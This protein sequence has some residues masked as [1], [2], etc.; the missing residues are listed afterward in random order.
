MGS[1]S[2]LGNGIDINI[3]DTPLPEGSRERKKKITDA[4]ECMSNLHDK[5]SPH[6]DELG[7]AIDISGN[8]PK[9]G[10]RVDLP[11]ARERMARFHDLPNDTQQLRDEKFAHI[12]EDGEKP[13]A[14]YSSDVKEKN[15]DTPNQQGDVPNKEV[16]TNEK[17]SELTSEEKKK[18]KEE[19][20]W[21]DE[22]IDAIGSMEEYEIYKKAGLVEQEIN[23]KKCLVR[24]DIDWEQKDSMG[25]TNKERV[26]QGLSPINKKGEVIELH[27]IGQHADS[28]LAE[29]TQEEH[30]GKG[31]DTIL[32]DKTKES[33]IDRQE[34][35]EERSKHWEERAK[36]ENNQDK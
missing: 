3:P 36:Q 27:H 18:I 20:G 14:E 24:Q 28:P 4:R 35:A 1:S 22:T 19:T 6:R 15:G 11:D 7:R 17:N 26:E 8:I 2:K 10:R 32:H 25:R 21:S 31:N 16:D 34:F 30:R 13:K 33:E 9:S 12:R 5:L 29:L 23:G